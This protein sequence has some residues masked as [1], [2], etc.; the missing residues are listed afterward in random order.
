MKRKPEAV[1]ERKAQPAEAAVY[2][3]QPMN[4]T[5]QVRARSNS[6]QFVNINVYEDAAQDKLGA[7]ALTDF[8]KRNHKAAGRE[9]QMAESTRS[10][11]DEIS[12]VGKNEEGDERKLD[13]HSHVGVDLFPGAQGR[14]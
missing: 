9:S 1:A 5:Q 13:T 2:Q 3:Q 14:I 7:T 8:V 11:H 6:S 4:Q 10:S 12:Q